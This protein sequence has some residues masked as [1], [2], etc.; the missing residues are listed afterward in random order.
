MET[1][2]GYLNA[3]DFGACGSSFETIGHVTASSNRIT[4]Q[5]TGDF[6]IGQEINMAGCLPRCECFRIFG[7]KPY[8]AQHRKVENEVEIRGWDASNGNHVVYIMDVDINAPTVFRWSDDQGRTWH[9]DVPIDGIWHKLSGGLEVRFNPEHDWTQGWVVTVVMRA[10]LIAQIIAI[11]GNTLVIDKEATRSCEDRII[12]SDTLALQKA[13]DTA[14]E[15]GKNLWIPSGTYRLSKSLHVN[16]ARSLTI[17]GDNP[18][19]IKS[20]FYDILF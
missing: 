14:I 20:Y 2:L 12:H 8:H 18:E 16:N 19:E 9:D 13:I 17:R 7:P 3:K 11:E 5:N 6:E 4:V 10:A 1:M 15:Q